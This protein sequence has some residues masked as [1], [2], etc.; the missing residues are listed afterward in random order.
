MRAAS[1]HR[2][3]DLSGQS[4]S[5][6]VYVEWTKVAIQVYFESL[7]NRTIFVEKSFA[8]VLKC[9]EEY[10]TVEGAKAKKLVGPIYIV[11]TR[12]ISTGCVALDRKPE[13]GRNSSGIRFS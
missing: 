1:A 2:V 8:P 6:E 13:H 9:V 10:Y 7:E 3:I 12:P 11:I 4:P 5:A